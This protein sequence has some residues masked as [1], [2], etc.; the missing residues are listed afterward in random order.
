MD[1]LNKFLYFN[2]NPEIK[3]YP[4]IAFYLGVIKSKKE[5]E[6][7]LISE[8]LHIFYFRGKIDFVASGHFN[9]RYFHSKFYPI[10]FKTNIDNIINELNNNRYVV[11][12][13][14]EKYL[15]SKDTPIEIDDYHD[16]IIY[17]YNKN[18]KIFYCAGYIGKH[19]HTR[20]YDT[21]Q[22]N[23]DDIENSLKNTCL[24]RFT[25][26]FHGTHSTWLKNNSFNHLSNENINH[27]LHEFLFP[28]KIKFY[29]RPLINL[30]TDAIK[31]FSKSILSILDNYDQL[32]EKPL[33]LKSFRILYEHSKVLLM[34]IKEYAPCDSLL[35]DGA[36]LTKN[37]YMLLLMSTKY[38]MH[39]EYDLLK[40]IYDKL[41]YSYTLEKSI[42]KKI[43]FHL[44][45]K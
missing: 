12:V 21:I 4:Y 8:F 11:I 41:M 3:T 31:K 36:V 19:I 23:F 43:I 42:I 34:V 18:D 33:H 26:S 20:K 39:S 14:N 2:A 25:F 40:S 22:L 16:W 9:K 44:E 7:L 28:T 17:G 45:Q 10:K 15:N 38:N 30:D 6:K 13:L 32:A 29:Y 37:M 27:H 35:S 1:N 5:I 24:N